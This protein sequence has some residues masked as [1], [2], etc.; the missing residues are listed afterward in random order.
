MSLYLG[1]NV[2]IFSGTIR[3]NLCVGRE[4]IS[5]QELSDALKLSGFESILKNSP[6]D[7][8]SLF[9]KVGGSCLEGNDKFLP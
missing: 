4:D 5:D 8:L 1:Q 6:M 2:G 9:L 3:E 7:F